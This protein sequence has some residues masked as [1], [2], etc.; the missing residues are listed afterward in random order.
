MNQNHLTLDANCLPTPEQ[1]EADNA[2][3]DAALDRLTNF[4]KIQFDGMTGD[5]QND[6]VKEIKSSHE[7]ATK[8]HHR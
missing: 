6:G 4:V 8:T 3:V 5:V 1:I 7:H 2:L